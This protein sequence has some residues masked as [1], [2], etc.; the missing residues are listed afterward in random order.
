VNPTRRG[1]WTAL[2]LAA[3]VLAAPLAAAAHAAEAHRDAGPPPC[4]D[5][6]LHLCASRPEPHADP[7]VLCRAGAE[8]AA[9]ET[10]ALRIASAPDESA[11][12]AAPGG[13]VARTLFPSSAPR[14][15]PA[16]DLR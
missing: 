6:S 1:S 2:A 11:P 5:P 10:P 14:A 16:D 13:P 15:P 4:E 7:C 8:R 9:L 12:E 3:F